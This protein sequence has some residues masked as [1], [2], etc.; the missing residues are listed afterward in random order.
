MHAEAISTLLEIER[1]CDTTAL[2]YNGVCYWPLARLRIWSS[3]MSRMVFE[4]N[5]G[6]NAV[7]NTQPT[8]EVL[9]T[10]VE[11]AS[12][13]SPMLGLLRQVSPEPFESKRLRPEALFFARPEEHNDKLNGQ[14]YAKMSDSVNRE[15]AKR[16]QTLKLELADAKSINFA[17]AVP[18]VFLDI[19]TAGQTVLYDAPSVLQNLDA[20]LAA[21]GAIDHAIV[22]DT[23]ALHTDMIK[24]FNFARIFEKL[25]TVLNPRALF[26][27]VY[28]HPVG[29]AWMLACRWLG[30]TTV[31]L[32]H[33][34]LGPHHGCYTQLSAAPEGGYELL[35]DVV[36]TWGAQT[37]HDIEVDK[38][39]EC[40]R[41]SGLVGGNPWLHLW[42]H[43]DT[44][45]L[46]PDS[47]RDFAK[48]H[49]GQTK[50]LASL[51][52]LESP[53][54]PA[55]LEAMQKAPKNWLWLLRL[56]PL[57]RHTAGE[58]LTMLK[59]AG[60]SNVDVEN[61]TALPLFTLL[62]MADHHVTV[63]SS[64]VV[65]AASFGLRS[66][67]IGPEGREIFK[68]RI[69]AGSAAYT[70]TADEL[71]KHITAC[72]QLTRGEITDDFIDMRPDVMTEAIDT[73]MSGALYS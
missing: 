18:S 25:L 28:Y 59:R 69:D 30:I 35:P 40:L 14:A 24:I 66:S 52:P 41:H 9:D 16:F 46:E 31:D 71:L 37:K 39:K 55:L 44:A 23:A 70:P 27:S 38:N 53:I 12:V 8:F 34:R 60:V 19:G 73:I 64:V 57:R 3:L 5:A 47:A 63:F 2:T 49:E 6:T 65:E 68:G 62:K 42:K 22:L 11:I 20:L 26:H 67:V 51:Q 32:Q 17:R 7:P 50:I 21:I 13:G 29:M 43:G 56:H 15:A 36:W 61:A 10:Q 45:G 48:A 58:V 1:R 72:L 54:G 4:K 33:G